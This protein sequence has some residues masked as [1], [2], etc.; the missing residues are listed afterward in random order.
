MLVMKSP[1]ATKHTSLSVL[2]GYSLALDD[3]TQLIQDWIKETLKKNSTLLALVYRFKIDN[4][5]IY[6]GEQFLNTDI[7]KQSK[8]LI[9]N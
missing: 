7:E 5:F 3:K 2:Q 8:C 9:W 4:T 6:I 1:K